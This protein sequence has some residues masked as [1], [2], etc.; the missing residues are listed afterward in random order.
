M[1]FDIKRILDPIVSWN[2]IIEV[3]EESWNAYRTHADEYYARIMTGNLEP[4][5][6]VSE[7]ARL[8][9]FVPEKLPPYYFDS[10]FQELVKQGH[11]DRLTNSRTSGQWRHFA[12]E[13]V[14]TKLR[15][16]KDVQM[17]PSG[18]VLS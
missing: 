7:L 4:H 9:H 11:E 16:A 14:S 18:L 13:A 6:L 10:Q 8:E 1:G 5:Y 3:S 12:W 15:E 17:T 2:M